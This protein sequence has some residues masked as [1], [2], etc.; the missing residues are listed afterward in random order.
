MRGWLAVA[1]ATVKMVLGGREDLESALC[2][3]SRE[4]T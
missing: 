3:V 2:K 1:E 4:G